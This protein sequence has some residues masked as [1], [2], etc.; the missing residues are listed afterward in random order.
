MYRYIIFVLSIQKGD[1]S[2]VAILLAFDADAYIRNRQGKYPIDIASIGGKVYNR[3]RQF[4]KPPDNEPLILSSLPQDTESVD[5][6]D[7]MNERIGRLLQ[8]DRIP[9]L[10]RKI[11]SEVKKLEQ[12]DPEDIETAFSSLRN[13]TVSEIDQFEA[14]NNQKIYLNRWKTT[15][16]SRVLFLDGG[17]IRGLIQIEILMELERRTGRKITELFDWIVGSSTG[18]IVALGLVY[19]EYE[20]RYNGIL[21]SYN[22]LLQLVKVLNKCDKSISRSKVTS[23]WHLDLVLS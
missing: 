19:G 6:Q 17:G 10:V 14:L 2:Y 9:A 11:D 8:H 3:L 7:L 1:S 15:A 16:G 18:G 5:L 22:I 21:L 4:P 20:L 12:G 23:L 13:R